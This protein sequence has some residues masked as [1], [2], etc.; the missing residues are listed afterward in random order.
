[1]TPVAAGEHAI[2]AEFSHEMGS[3]NYII[4]DRPS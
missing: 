4:L 2:V 3:R 1:M